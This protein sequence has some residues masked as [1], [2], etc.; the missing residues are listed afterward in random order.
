MPSY[1]HFNKFFVVVISATEWPYKAMS[2][3]PLSDEF[4][5]YLYSADPFLGS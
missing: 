3:A 5:M 4:L 2:M 1:R